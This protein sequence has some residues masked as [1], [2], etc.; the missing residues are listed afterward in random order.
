VD[1]MDTPRDDTRLNLH[2]E[3]GMTRRDLMRR[4]AVVGGT[5]LWVAPAIQ[6]IGAKAYAQ[7]LSPLCDACIAVTSTGATQHVH[8]I[9]SVDCCACLAGTGGNLAA[10]LRCATG[11]A[12]ACEVPGPGNP[13]HQ[14]ACD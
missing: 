8:I 14:G 7:G 9:P 5:L 1:E 11:P 4:G 2:D 10:I 3:S 13:V 6:S 12:P